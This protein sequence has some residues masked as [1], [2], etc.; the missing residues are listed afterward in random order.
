MPVFA[1]DRS[2]GGEGFAVVGFGEERQES[3]SGARLI[4][5][6]Q[7]LDSGVPD[8]V[9]KKDAEV[10]AGAGSPVVDRRMKASRRGR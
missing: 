10:S 2:G 4:A 7:F 6:H 1:P 8:A 5:P 9:L 3:P